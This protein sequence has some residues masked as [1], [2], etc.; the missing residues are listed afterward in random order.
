MKFYFG[1]F[2]FFEGDDKVDEERESE[3]DDEI[4]GEEEW[5]WNYNIL[6]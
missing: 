5:Y 4:K 6:L 2:C 3:R 1:L